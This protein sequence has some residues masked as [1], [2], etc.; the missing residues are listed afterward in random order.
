MFNNI[1]IYIYYLLLIC[2]I[3]KKMFFFF[4]K[5]Y[6]GKKMFFFEKKYIGKKYFK[7]HNVRT[8]QGNPPTHPITTIGKPFLDRKRRTR[9]TAGRERHVPSACL[10]TTLCHQRIRWRGKT[11]ITS[12]KKLQ[13]LRMPST[14]GI[15]T[16]KM[17]DLVWLVYKRSKT[18]ATYGSFFYLF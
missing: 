5:K 6:I 16:T 18:A 7:Q 2:F 10:P 17:Q 13:L 9:Q 14:P 11:Y 8:Q 4:E 3:G 1:Y 15:D 12:G